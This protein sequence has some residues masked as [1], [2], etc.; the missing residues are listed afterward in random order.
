M[1]LCKI[2]TVFFIVKLSNTL[3]AA[4]KF[5]SLLYQD[6]LHK[7]TKTSIYRLP[8]LCIYKAPAV[9]MLQQLPDVDRLAHSTSV[10]G[11]LSSVCLKSSYVLE[12][13]S[14]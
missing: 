8:W 6:V 2:E 4:E 10:L 7:T 11:F 12:I 1:F 3:E 5:D 9:N 14:C 13:L